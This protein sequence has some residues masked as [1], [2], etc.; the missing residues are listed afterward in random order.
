MKLHR[1]SFLGAAAGAGALTASSASPTFAAD[2]SDEA[3]ETAAAKP[4]LNRAAF[5][6]PVIIESITLVEG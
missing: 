1:R 4:V 6:E 3:L 2:I 5:K